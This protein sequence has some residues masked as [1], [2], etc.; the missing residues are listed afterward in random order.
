M[1]ATKDY[2]A[3][4]ECELQERLAR[5]GGVRLLCL[6]CR[7]LN[8]ADAQFCSSCGTKFNAVVAGAA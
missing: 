3:A 5:D 6:Q 2:R 1:T 4:I 7:G 8:D